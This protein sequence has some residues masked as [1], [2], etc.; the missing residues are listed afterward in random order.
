MFENNLQHVRETVKI[1]KI[2]CVTNVESTLNVILT[3]IADCDAGVMYQFTRY[4][5]MFS[6]KR[7]QKN[8]AEIEREKQ[9]GEH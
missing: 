9:P 2:Y 6:E 8:P 5:N 3:E 4:D 1:A 7:K